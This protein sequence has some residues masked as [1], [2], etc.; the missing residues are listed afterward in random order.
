MRGFGSCCLV[1]LTYSSSYATVNGNMYFNATKQNN[2]WWSNTILYQIYPRSFKDS[3]KDGIGDLKGI[4]A[5]KMHHNSKLKSSENSLNLNFVI[6][7]L[8]VKNI[9]VSFYIILLNV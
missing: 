8:K 5:I 1:I 7:L 9:E 4:F 6:T 2:E 3:N